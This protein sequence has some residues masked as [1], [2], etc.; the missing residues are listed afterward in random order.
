MKI[1]S[2]NDALHIQKDGGPE[3]W[4]YLSPEYEIHYNEQP[5]HSGQV[6]H[7][8]E[9]IS[10]TVYMID[11]RMVALWRGQPIVRARG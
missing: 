9:K 1:I 3:V 2:K 6:W 8:H 11:G 7:K 10:E 5:P 4:Y